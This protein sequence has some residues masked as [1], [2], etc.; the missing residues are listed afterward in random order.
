MSPFSLRSRPSRAILIPAVLVTILTAC[1][2]SGS[3]SNGSGAAPSAAPAAAPKP[4]GEADPIAAEIAKQVTDAM[5][6]QA[7]WENLP[8]LRFDF[9]VVSEGQERARFRHWW[10]KKRGRVRVEGPDEKGQIVAAAFGLADKKGISFTGG[11]PDAD[12]ASIASHIQNG[13]ER[14]VNDTYWL[15]MPFKLRDPG[16]RLKHARTETGEA[17]QTYDV[18]E[19]SFQPG[20]GLT[21]QDRYWLYVNRETH[22]IDRWEF[23]LTG[24]Q[25][26]PQGSS[27][28]SYSSVGPLR[29]SLVRR[30]RDRPAMLRFDNVSAPEAMDE[31]VFTHSKIMG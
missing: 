12:S 17:G 11:M 30:F 3:S 19:L 15:I 18:L 27:W 6:G 4:Q 20:V 26:P 31:K 21:P 29:L 10:D 2:Q 22:L 14:W 28:E 8:Y 16:T 9:V 25:P 7:A 13:Y 24:R 1:S 5:G 23:V